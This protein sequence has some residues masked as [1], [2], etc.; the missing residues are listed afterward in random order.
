MSAIAT[1]IL[2]GLSPATSTET[3]QEKFTSILSKAD[4]AYGEYLAGQCVTCH[5]P[6]GA[7]Q[8]I[9]HIHGL[10]DVYLVQTLL[11]YKAGSEGRTNPAM[12]NIAKNL[13]EEELG[14][15]AKYFSEQNPTE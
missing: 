8:G 4:P 6:T 1:L 3:Q 2:F 5:V 15:L 7:A 12:V 14:S 9:P 13:S 10:P 11:E